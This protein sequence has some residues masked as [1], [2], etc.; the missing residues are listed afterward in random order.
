MVDVVSDYQFEDVDELL[1]TALPMAHQLAKLK[2]AARQ[3]GVPVIY[4]NDN[5]GN[6]QEDF[7]SSVKKI[8]ESSSPK[9]A[10]IVKLLE[11]ASDD[12]YI[13]KPQ[14]SAF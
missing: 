13:L 4:V 7:K 6:W 10:V 8:L 1:V 3:A 5:L 9:A 2:K 14:R 12:Y 11:P